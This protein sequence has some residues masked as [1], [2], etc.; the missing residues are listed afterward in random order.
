MVDIFKKKILIR[1]GFF[2]LK[3]DAQKRMKEKAEYGSVTIMLD[4]EGKHPEKIKTYHIPRPRILQGFGCNS[5]RGKLITRI[6]PKD[7]TINCS[8]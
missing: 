5:K 1:M 8:K 6:L 4:Q 7:V 3:E 2:D